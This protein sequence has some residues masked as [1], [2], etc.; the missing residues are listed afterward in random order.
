MENE[1]YVPHI[2]THLLK[3]FCNS[4]DRTQWKRTVCRHVNH[5][6]LSGKLF[7]AFN[8]PLH[9]VRVISPAVGG[10]FEAK[11]AQLRRHNHTFISK[12]VGKPVKLTF[13]REE[14]MICSFVRQG[15]LARI[16]TGVKKDEG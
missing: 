13:T 11:Q 6:M 3:P 10:G 5:L 8:L 15:C 9:K 1:F 14:D 4:F 16:K 12:C 7:V 2:N